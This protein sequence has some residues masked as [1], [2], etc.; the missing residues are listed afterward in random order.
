MLTR[1]SRILVIVCSFPSRVFD[2]IL[3]LPISNTTSPIGS[4]RGDMH[5]SRSSTSKVAVVCCLQRLGT[6]NKSHVRTDA[7]VINPAVT[8]RRWLFDRS[9]S[10]M[11]GVEG[12]YD[13]AHRC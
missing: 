1:T 3:Q 7:E 13:D 12:N 5:C 11:N 6:G 8:Y 10:S 2:S 4:F 9:I